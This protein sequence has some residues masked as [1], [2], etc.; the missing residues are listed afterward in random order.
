MVL[1]VTPYSSAEVHQRFG[2]NYRLHFH[3]KSL[4][5]TRK[6]KAIDSSE[7]LMDSYQITRRYNPEGR[8]FHM[9]YRFAITETKSLIIFGVLFHVYEADSLKGVILLGT[10]IFSLLFN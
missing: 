7:T 1:V 10:I 3:G 5:K 6:M 2:G 9:R 4:S 8:V